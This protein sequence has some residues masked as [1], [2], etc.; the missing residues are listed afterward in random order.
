MKQQDMETHVTVLG[1]LF[2]LHNALLVMIGVLGWLFMAGLG[3]FASVDSG[4]PPAFGILVTIGTV[5]LLFFSLLALPGLL[6]G[7]GL[8]KRAS[9]ARLLALVVGILG[10]FN[11]PVG[12]AIGVYTVWV[13]M[14][15]EVADT[16]A[17]A[18][19]T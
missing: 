17:V 14:Q 12:T 5:G 13:L 15:E 3:F 2:L 10:L 4:N 16:F 11:F 9:W 7:Y 8:L 19:V 1:W 6:A 18:K